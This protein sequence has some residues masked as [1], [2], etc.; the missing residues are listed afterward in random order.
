MNENKEIFNLINDI[1]TLKETQLEI[2]HIM[3]MQ[4]QEID[5]LRF[6]LNNMTKEEFCN[7]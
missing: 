7:D 6:K 5:K 1:N 4:Q 3:Q 2:V